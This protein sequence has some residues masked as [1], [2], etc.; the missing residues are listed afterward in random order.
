MKNQHRFSGAAH[1]NEEFLFPSK[2][3]K[4]EGE[5]DK[6]NAGPCK[7]PFLFAGPYVMKTYGARLVKNNPG[8]KQTVFGGQVWPGEFYRIKKAVI[9]SK[10]DA[11]YAMGGGKVMDLAKLIKKDIPGI[12]LINIPTSAATCA[13]M[14]PVSVMYTKDGEY[15]GT[16]DS[17]VPDEVVVDYDIMSALPMPFFAAGAADAL[18]K[19]YETFAARRAL[20]NK[21]NSFDNMSFAVSAGCKDAL[22]EIIYL[23]WHKAD[24]SVRKELADINIIQSGLASCAG[25]FS[26]T[27]LI[28]HA[29]AHAATAVTAARQYLHGEH[30][31]AGLIM[32]ETMLKGKKHLVELNSFFEIMEL[33]LGLAG[34]GL[35]K[36]DLKF[37]FDKYT[38]IDNTEKISVYAGKKLVYNTLE[39]YL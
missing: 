27:G 10:A 38:A 13:A 1:T 6:I 3:T 34:I 39:A 32:Q 22:K 26:I 14:T 35:K 11:L 20:K 31:A 17:A 33:P 9:D 4:G 2:V 8:I 5:L 25:R 36:P 21:L 30:A 16:I 18:A 24:D 7:A 12:K 37:F 23:K 29:A 19:Y 15:T 28:A